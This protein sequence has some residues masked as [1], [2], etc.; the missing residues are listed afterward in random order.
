M[1]EKLAING[2]TPVRKN[3]LPP[4]YPGATMFNAEETVGLAE[5]VAA[6]SPF[7]P[8]KNEAV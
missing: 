2:G 6:K 4:S 8:W 3:P 5:V 7:L 1:S